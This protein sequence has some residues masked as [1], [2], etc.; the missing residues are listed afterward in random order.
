MSCARAS[1]WLP[2][3]AALALTGAGCSLV[4]TPVVD[5][6]VGAPDADLDGGPDADVDAGIDAY[7]EPYDAGTDAGTDAYVLRELCDLRG[8]ED[9]DDLADCADP[10][11]FGAP[12]CCSD[13]VGRPLG[14]TFVDDEIPADWAGTALPDTST[15]PGEVQL[16]FG[17]GTYLRR[18][19]CL[20]LGQGARID[21]ALRSLAA[22][23]ALSVVL[24]PS[25]DPTDAMAGR[26]LDELALR[27]EDGL[28]SA[29]RAGVPLPLA[30]P[31]ATCDG[32][33]VAGDP[34]H[35]RLATPTRLIV[36]MRPGVAFGASA[37]LVTVDVY[38]AFPGGCTQVR[39]LVDFPIDLRDLRRTTGGE[40]DACD[41]SPGLYFVLEGRQRPFA[42]GNS[43]GAVPATPNIV[44]SPLECSSPGVFA[45]E[46]PILTRSSLAASVPAD[47]FAAGG[48]GAPDLDYDGVAR[49]WLL[50]VDGS[51]EDRS[52]ELFQPLT[53]R[54]GMSTAGS[55][56]QSTWTSVPMADGTP[57]TGTTGE[58]REPSVLLEG[59]NLVLYARARSMGGG[60][61]LYHAG[62]PTLGVLGSPARL[63][64]YPGCSYREPVATAGYDASRWLFLRCDQ[65]SGSS[66]AV[67][68]LNED[69]SVTPERANLL[70]GVADGIAARVVAADVLTRLSA[71]RRYFAVWVLAD[72]G[73]TA[74]RELHLFVGEEA[75]GTFPTTFRPYAG[76]PVLT[77]AELQESCD[78]PCDVTSF[79]VASEAV[80]GSDRLRF[81]FAR[82]RRTATETVYELLP[83]SQIA[84]SA[85]DDGL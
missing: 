44:L 63:D 14:P 21:L 72:R 83:R 16:D 33:R 7:V 78:T 77:Q 41:E 60:F 49:T 8:D 84:P 9:E 45:V 56:S 69:L 75:D 2:A 38:G 48:V 81:L 4:W 67:A 59:T 26:F 11:C 62:M 42:V 30:S 3:L 28:F 1:R 22:S 57:V 12:D 37:L 31:S 40:V 85:L 61:D 71:G 47:D 34:A 58:V 82:T 70:R 29:T 5:P 10:D 36:R 24:S 54:I 50:S 13:D 66:L 68:R 32:V 51:E 39:P 27:F 73:G 18:R 23:G 79:A 20:P 19:R 74:P 65:A 15:M 55:V 52:S 6:D 53:T 25:P 76:N 35:L 64:P 43:N 80:V 46:R 17:A